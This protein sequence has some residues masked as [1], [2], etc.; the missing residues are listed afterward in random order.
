MASHAEHAPQRRDPILGAELF[1]FELSS[2]LLFVGRQVGAPRE[3]LEL[4]V[5]TPMLPFQFVESRGLSLSHA[6]ITF[7]YHGAREG[8]FALSLDDPGSV[9]YGPAPALTA[10][11][12][13]ARPRELTEAS[14]CLFFR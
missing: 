14:T 4:R 7:P 6:S 1:L 11:A 8:S 10:A 13:Q 12:E 3:Y 5:Q 9:A 2:N